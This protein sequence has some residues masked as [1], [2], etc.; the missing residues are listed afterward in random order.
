MA[1]GPAISRSIPVG[2]WRDH[3]IRFV[4]QRH[5]LFQMAGLQLASAL[6]VPSV[7]FVPATLVWE[8]SQWEVRRPGWATWL[9]RFGEAPCAAGRGSRGVWK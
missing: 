5:D 8:S 4:W 6:D 9:E 1:T 7:V 2:P 3:D